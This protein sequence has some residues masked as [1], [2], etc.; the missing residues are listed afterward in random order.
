MSSVVPES[1]AESPLRRVKKRHLIQFIQFGMVGGSGVLVNF[2]VYYV[3][4][5]FSPVDIHDVLFPLFVFGKNFRFYHL[6]SSIAFVVANVWNF[7]LNRAWTFRTGGKSSR[8]RFGR[9]F[10][11]GAAA[12]V[13]GLVIM[14]FLLHPASPIHLPFDVLDGSTG[15]RKPD[16]WAQAIQVVATMPV[17]FVLQ[18]LW[19]FAAHETDETDDADDADDE[20]A[21]RAPGVPPHGAPGVPPHGAPEGSPRA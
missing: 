8:K 18:K 13:V 11:I 1:P 16:Y 17:S 10:L 2:A 20:P 7:E 5:R 4:R 15:L 21:S 12:Q 9:Y 3:L 6:Y 14:S 19:T